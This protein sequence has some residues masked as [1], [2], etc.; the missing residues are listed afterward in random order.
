M[1]AA[2][3]CRECS[4]Q[5]AP[6]GDVLIDA[7]LTVQSEVQQGAKRILIKPQVPSPPLVQSLSQKF[8]QRF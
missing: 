1:G 8:W 4:F 3:S 7:L 2:H 5:R 6:L